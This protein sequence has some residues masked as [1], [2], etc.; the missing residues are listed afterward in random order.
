MGQMVG[1]HYIVLLLVEIVR[2]DDLIGIFLGV[3]GILLQAD[4]DLAEIHGRGV[5]S[6]G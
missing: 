2:N 6:K 5:C 3:N 1:L 4:I